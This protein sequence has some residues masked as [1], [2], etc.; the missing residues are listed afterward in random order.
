M[1]FYFFLPCSLF[2]CSYFQGENKS[3]HPYR[4]PHRDFDHRD[5]G[6]NASACIE[7]SP[8][9][10]SGH[11]MH[12]K[13]SADS[14]CYASISRRQHRRLVFGL[15]GTVSFRKFHYGQLC[16]PADCLDGISAALHG[17]QRTYNDHPQGPFRF[18]V[19]RMSIPGFP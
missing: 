11:F 7:Q 3:F 12:R 4:A 17:T 15:S 18:R 6:G 16:I 2:F 1:F 9:N 8:S 19:F 13:S 5:S 10:C 14:Y